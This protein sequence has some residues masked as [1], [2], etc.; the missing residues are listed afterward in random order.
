[1]DKAAW[2]RLL[3]VWAAEAVK[4]SGVKPAAGPLSG[5]GFPGAVEAELLAAEWRLGCRLP[6]SYREFLKCTNGL[7]QPSEFVPARG[8]DFWSAEELDWFRVRNQAWIDAW[9]TYDTFV[10]PDELYFVYG[11][12]QDPIYL[13]REYL[14]HTLEI[15][16]RGDSSVYLLNPKIVGADNEWE[17]WFL[18]NWAPGANRYRSFAEM[19]LAHYEGFQSEGLEGLPSQRL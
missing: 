18:A 10:I 19:M 1:M 7:R 17:A 11:P 3:C 8:G 14:E 4:R 13:R 9:T 5:L 12:A 15:S 16:T 6:P 2:Q